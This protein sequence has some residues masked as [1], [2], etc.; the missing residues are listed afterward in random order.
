MPG[1]VERISGDRNPYFRRDEKQIRTE[2][3]RKAIAELPKSGQPL[4]VIEDGDRIILKE[5]IGERLS[6]LG[7]SGGDATPE[8]KRAIAEKIFQTVDRKAAEPQMRSDS[9]KGV[10]R[11]RHLFA[12]DLTL[13]PEERRILESPHEILLIHDAD[14]R[15]R[16]VRLGTT[17]EVTIPLGTARD[18]IISH[19]HPSGR[20]P[21]DSD[22]KSAL[23]NPGRMLRI[24]TV[25]E[26]REIE[27]FSLKANM[28]LT[29]DEV[30]DIADEYREFCENMGDGPLARR[31]ALAL[32]VAKH[33]GIFTAGRAIVR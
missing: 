5:G 29:A 10:A 30:A 22:L 4:R 16:S 21:S 6:K 7:K 17:H 27:V 18:A 3:Y 28:E 20:G 13:T 33:E 2:K 1:S 15:L 31:K 23:A 26:D 12:A 8:Q 14:G 9:Q 24:V 25:N 19:N 32:I 11:A